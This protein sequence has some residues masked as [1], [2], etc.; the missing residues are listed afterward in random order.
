[1]RSA[2][3]SVRPS[4]PEAQN[5]PIQTVPPAY[6]S[7]IFHARSTATENNSICA[8]AEGLYPSRSPN[9]E[10]QPVTD[11]SLVVSSEQNPPEM[12]PEVN[13]PPALPERLKKSGCLKQQVEVGGLISAN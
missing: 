7:D 11:T 5:S 6:V 3:A 8:T 13:P 2:D 10:S 1:M 4:A 9:A 12:K